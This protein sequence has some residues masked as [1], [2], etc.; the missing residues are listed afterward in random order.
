MGHTAWIGII[1][2]HTSWTSTKRSTAEKQAITG[3]QDLDVSGAKIAQMWRA[4]GAELFERNVFEFWGGEVVFVQEKARGGRDAAAAPGGVGGHEMVV[5]N[6]RKPLFGYTF[7]G[8]DWFGGKS[9]KN[10][11]YNYFVGAN[12]L[13][14]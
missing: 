6:E 2:K 3:L 13:C 12:F 9:N 14:R 8:E 4:I 5:G 1:T 11:G 10:F 7:E